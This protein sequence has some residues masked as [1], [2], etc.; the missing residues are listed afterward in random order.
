M[1]P[2]VNVRITATDESRPSWRA[3][4]GSLGRARAEF[5]G[6]NDTVKGLQAATRTGTAGLDAITA[7]ITLLS[8]GA[9]QAGT[10]AESLRRLQGAETALQQALARSNLTLDQ[11]IFLGEQL[12]RVQAVL[13][14]TAARTGAIAGG[15]AAAG[16]RKFS[17]GLGQMAIQTIGA[18]AQLGRMGE[19]LL[20]LAGGGGAMLAAS[21]A[22]IA[23]VGVYKLLTAHSR[24]VVEQNKKM[25]DSLNDEAQNAV[26]GLTQAYDKLNAALEER[27]RHRRNLIADFSL[28]ARLR[29]S[30]V[31]GANGLAALLGF[32]AD[33]DA[34]ALGK[35]GS[36]VTQGQTGIDQAAL[37]LELDRADA[38]SRLISLGRAQTDDFLSATFAL[39]GLT[40]QEA[41]LRSELDHG[42][43]TVDARTKLTEK[44]VQ[45][46]QARADLEKALHDHA[47]EATAAGEKA[48]KALVGETNALIALSQLR[49][50]SADQMTRLQTL[51]E[52]LRVLTDRHTGSIQEQTAAQKAYNAAIA[53]M[54]RLTA[55][56]GLGVRG[57]SFPGI[58]AAPAG[59]AGANGNPTA[60]VPGVHLAFGQS[61]V[62]QATD[63]AMHLGSGLSDYLKAT[64]STIGHSYDTLVT[65]LGEGADR[66]RARIRE[67]GLGLRDELNQSLANGIGDAIVAAATAI[68]SGNDLGEAVLA[69]VGRM[70]V[71]LG[72][73]LIS[74]GL[75]MTHLLPAFSN[76]ITAGPAALAAGAALV[77]LGS[78]F[79]TIVNSPNP[80]GGAAGAGSIAAQTTTV[81]VR[82][83]DTSR[84]A[85]IQPRQPFVFAPTIIGVND[86]TAQRSVKR[87]YDLA[88]E[89]GV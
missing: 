48:R 36:A 67:I 71:S 41:R 37:Q 84:S 44:L 1:A 9:E 82:D 2:Q 78:A 86:P 72:A 19:G 18:N 76:P 7:R 47:E 56:P 59:P 89:R 45:V 77:A 50:L 61:L 80:G 73:A 31:P 22:G 28:I 15:E 51:T 4:S 46:Q 14:G 13:G 24:E 68:G 39:D 3:L 69:V 81:V 8:R 5:L 66:V 11:Q 12:A 70:M 26:P 33:Q 40:E 64:S 29:A 53:E 23:L 60:V 79:S 74:Y 75:V 49:A 6:L 42:N 30:G 16:A 21:A 54:S 63:T 20:L 32:V 25:V 35:A 83:V 87:M 10:R 58:E 88:V 17:S 43:I 62:S 52:Q 57:Q 34:N 38:L 65:A 55:A 27:D 85:A